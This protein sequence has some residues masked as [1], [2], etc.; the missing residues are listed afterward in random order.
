[1]A[2]AEVD[3]AAAAVDAVAAAA[4]AA[5]V[6]SFAVVGSAWDAGPVVEDEGFA[7]T[8]LESLTAASCCSVAGAA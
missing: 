6:P 2:I 4:D 5:V 1:M 7:G 3:A 8:G